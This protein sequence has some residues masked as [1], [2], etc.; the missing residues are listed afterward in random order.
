MMSRNTKGLIGWL[1]AVFG[2]A[3]LGGL[4]PGDAPTFYRQ[5]QLPP[6]APPGWLFGPAW[7]LLYPMLGVAAWLVWRDRGWAGARVALGLFIAQLLANL[8]WSYLF[9]SFRMGGVAFAEV[10]LLWCLLAATAIAFWRIR[11]LAGVLLLPCLGWVG[12]AAALNF[13]TWRMN[14]QLLGG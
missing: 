1:A 10:L 2:V 12:F 5:L 13:V 3:A 6:W 4:A 11:P 8:L 7:G 9:F 14:P